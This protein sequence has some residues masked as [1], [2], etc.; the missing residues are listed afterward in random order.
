MALSIPAELEQRSFIL[1][2]TLGVVLLS[3]FING[4]TIRHLIAIVGLDKYSL[5]EK[6]E[7]SQAILS[8]M[9]QAVEKME[10]LANQGAIHK[11]VFSARKE[12]YER[13]MAALRE[14]LAQF[15]Q[16]HTSFKYEDE[17]E[18]ILRHC[19]MLERVQYHKLFEEGRLNEDNL[20]EMGHLID[21]QLDRVKEG[22][23]IS[24]LKEQPSLFNRLEY[25]FLKV[26]GGLFFLRPITRRYKT[27]RIAAGY[28][29]ERARHLVS[30]AL[31]EGIEKM[32]HQKTVSA[33]P[34]QQAKELY[35]KL[36]RE[37]KAR[38]ET[39]R[40]EFPQYV[41]KVEAGILTRLCLNNELE[42]F[43]Q[44]HSQGAI[45]EKVLM[46]MSEDI[47]NRLRSMRM[48]PVE[49]LLIPPC[50]LL[51]MVPYFEELKEEELIKLSSRLTAFSFLPG[52]EIVKEGDDGDSLFIIGRGQVDVSTMGDGQAVHLA[53]LKAGEFFGE[54]ALLHPQ[55]RTAT[56]RAATPCTLLELSRDK[57]LPY[58]EKATHLK[59][60]LEKAYQARILDTRLAHERKG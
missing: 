33:R 30:G 27:T 26:M 28:E 40:A 10:S 3:L 17:S 34:L 24:G 1:A 6:Y 41:E 42:T 60:I 49:E 43:T 18:V 59:D 12:S 51:R 25:A 48:R 55:P 45:S 57:L 38:V 56:V 39:I 29:M 35:Q 14:E 36:H 22:R 7:R 50:D 8:A 47:N 32:E 58:L 21:I 4:L 2:L 23:D 31:L 16:G 20:K 11:S 13:E 52:E 54:V 15:T 9:K 37:A 5:K 53:R 19:L 44:L 46:E